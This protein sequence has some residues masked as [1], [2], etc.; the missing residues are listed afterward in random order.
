[1][2]NFPRKRPLR[3]HR[4]KNTTSVPKNTAE[5]DR[6][7]QRAENY[8]SVPKNIIPRIDFLRVFP[9]AT[10]NINSV[11]PK[12]RENIIFCDA[13]RL[14]VERLNKLQGSQNKIWKM[15]LWPHFFEK[16]KISDGS[17]KLLTHHSPSHTP[18]FGLI[19]DTT[20]TIIAHPTQQPCSQRRKPWRQQQWRRRET[21]ATAA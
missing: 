13:W 21:N 8:T 11:P 2:R 12:S 16:K 15:A 6:S 4:A 18:Q 3:H 20:T 19:Y 1:M 9:C 7:Q 17:L 14:A 5:I 10:K